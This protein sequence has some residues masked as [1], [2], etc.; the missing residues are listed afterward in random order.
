M[1]CDGMVPLGP[2]RHLVSGRQVVETMSRGWGR[3][4]RAQA[5]GSAV[6][7]GHVLVAVQAEQAVV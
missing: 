1:S 4:T 5:L 2:H 7:G 3:R 6:R